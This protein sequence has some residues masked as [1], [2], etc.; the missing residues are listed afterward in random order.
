MPQ[1]VDSGNMD[2]DENVV[3]ARG[4]GKEL[5]LGRERPH[6]PGRFLSNATF[7]RRSD[8]GEGILLR[9]HA[10]AAFGVSFGDFTTFFRR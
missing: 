9:Q 10:I 1:G 4:T 3:V 6:T 5:R 2:D 8:P 7:S